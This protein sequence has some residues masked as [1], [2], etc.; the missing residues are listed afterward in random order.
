MTSSMSIAPEEQ[1]RLFIDRVRQENERGFGPP[2]RKAVQR[3]LSAG[4]PHPWM[5]VYELT[6]NARDAGARRVWWQANGSTV[7]FQHDGEEPLNEDHVTGLAS[8]GASTKGLAAIGFMGVGFKSVFARFRVARVT[9]NG[10]RFGFEVGSREG[11]L[12]VS[13]TEWFDTLRPKWDETAPQPEAGYT[14]AFVL[15]RPVEPARPVAEDLERITSTSDPTPLAV[16]ALRGLEEVR[17]GDVSW[18]LGVDDGVVEVRSPAVGGARRWKAFRS[19][20]RPDDDAMRRFLEVREELQDHIDAEGQRV[21]REVAALL[22]LD[23]HGIPSPPAHGRVY[24]T[25]P[26]QVPVPFGFHLQADW[27]VNVDRQNLREVAGDRWQEAI[28][29]QVPELVRQLFEWLAEDG[30]RARGYSALRDPRADDGLLAGPFQRLREELAE[31]LAGQP[32]VPIVGPRERRYRAP[33][34]VTR[35]PGQFLESFGK[36]PTWRAD[37]LFGHDLMDEVLMGERGSA[38]ARWLGWGRPLAASDVAWLES[39]PRWW[40]GLPA[41]AQIEA[42]FAL[43]EAIGQHQWNDAPVVPT[44]A[45]TWVKARDTRWLNEEPPTEKEQESPAGRVVAQALASVLPGDRERLPAGIRALVNRTD[46]TGT[47]WL[48]GQHREVKLAGLI[49][50]AFRA[51]KPEDGLA[52]VELLEWALSRGDRRQDLVPLVLTEQGPREP[53]KALLAD[54]LIEG[55]EARRQL[56]PDLPPLDEGYAVIDDTKAVV[57]FLVRLGVRGAGEL[58]VIME[59]L[60]RYE[61]AKVA[62]L[63]GIDGHTVEP[64]ND[65]GYKVIDYRFPFLV[66]EV[67]P[68][69]LQDWLSREH[70]ALAGKGSP[71]AQ[72]FF[73]TPRTM[74]GQAPAHW[75]R[76][77]QDHAWLLCTDGQRRRPA[78][79]LLE[80][81]LD[82]EGAPVAQIDRGLA[83]RLVAEGVRFGQTLQKSPALRRLVLRG[84]SELGDAALA[85]LLREALADVDAGEASLAELADALTQVRV[86]GV[87]PCSRL[88]QR[89]GSG[90]GLRSDLGRFVLPLSELE[91]SLRREMGR[92]DHPVPDTTTGARLSSSWLTPGRSDQAESRSSED[93]LRLPTGTS[94][95]I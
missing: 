66:T 47:R 26:T 33:E 80:P 67:A 17:V 19:R 45:D 36:E 87:Y 13:V 65:A 42:L 95:T 72:S 90:T 44:Q 9:G 92:L 1:R 60:G 18:S 52:L 63:L 2:A 68:D 8:L 40:S 7:V 21:E 71:I 55:G 16:L 84:S 37:V 59:P 76:Q 27:L 6:Q 69:S 39:L 23:E 31:A 89:A 81:D 75:V 15:E 57:L 73:H 11:D 54:P 51:A 38:F 85:Q 77:L 74:R 64:A 83:E 29:G 94:S 24:A 61:A 28:V 20:Y 88:I 49:E 46:H 50:R 30:A 79:V 12:D 43:W 86:R 10:W 70:R 58:H 53:R 5:Y 93:I 32:V 14:T 48:K 34:D 56:F 25:L 41:E 4:L 82:Y 22:P 78:D 91:E 62:T 35:L 3:L